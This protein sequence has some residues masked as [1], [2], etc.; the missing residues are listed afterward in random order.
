MNSPV[1]FYHIPKSAGTTLNSVLKKNYQPENFVECGI[2]TQAFMADMKTWPPDRLAQVRLL[3][4]HF[5]F[6]IHEL[7]PGRPRYFTLL[8]DP[9]DRVISYYYHA[10]REPL[11]YLHKHIHGNDWSLKDLLESRIPIMMNDA[12]V[13][14]ISGV[15]DTLPFNEVDERLLEQ[16][17][18]NL[19]TFAVV[20][21]MEQFDLTLL[22]LQ[23][24]FG[25][26]DI[27]YV[28]TNIGENRQP[29]EMHSAEIIET[30]R[31]YNRY[32]AMLYEE[33]RRLLAQQVKDAGLLFRLRLMANRFSQ[34]KT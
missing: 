29:A 30:V 26:R 28:T 10:K 24:A 12:Q 9:V 11:H 15:F 31:R 23:K 16:A 3:Q 32:D 21:V 6:G 5:P 7:L 2:N 20:G 17:I 14:L 25:W 33:A 27:N 19:R 18:T 8:R 34:N 13:R 22:L 4:G 1:I